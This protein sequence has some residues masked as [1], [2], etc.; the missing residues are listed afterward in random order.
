[1][2]QE[3]LNSGN[4]L[5]YARS[6]NTSLHEVTLEIAKRRHFRKTLREKLPRN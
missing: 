3:M 5:D 1:M 4:E 6:D 2:T